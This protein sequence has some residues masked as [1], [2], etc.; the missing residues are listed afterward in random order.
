MSCQTV[1]GCGVF[2]FCFEYPGNCLPWHLDLSHQF[3]PNVLYRR[4]S[5]QGVEWVTHP[6]KPDLSHKMGKL[7]THYYVELTMSS[8][9]S[10]QFVGV[11]VHLCARCKCYKTGESNRKTRL[12]PAVKT[13]VTHARA[14]SAHPLQNL[15]LHIL[16]SPFMHC[17]QPA[18]VADLTYCRAVQRQVSV[19]K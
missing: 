19:R 3:Q 4:H 6:E 9:N 15:S 1:I 12:V 16:Y 17:A 7:I 8:G 18:R 2:H 14:I 13:S 5:N 10:A 11:D